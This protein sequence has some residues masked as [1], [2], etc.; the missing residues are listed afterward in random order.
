MN[1]DNIDYVNKE[2]ILASVFCEGGGIVR[3]FL[4]NYL[5]NLHQIRLKNH[6]FGWEDRT[7]KT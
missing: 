7:R 5:T 1:S 3:D 2:T 6:V 4:R